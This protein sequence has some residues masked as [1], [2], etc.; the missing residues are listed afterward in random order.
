MVNKRFLYRFTSAFNFMSTK[1]HF[2]A[3]CASARGSYEQIKLAEGFVRRRATVRAA[4]RS[5]GC[6]KA[7]YG[8]K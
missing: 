8:K 2:F 1:P 4:G 6:P 7:Y 5:V 3:K